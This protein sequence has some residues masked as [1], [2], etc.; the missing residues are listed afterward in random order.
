MR[1]VPNTELK[2]MMETY[3]NKDR[4]SVLGALENKK[5]EAEKAPKSS[6]PAKS[7]DAGMEK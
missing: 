4:S 3:K 1:D 7:K 2:T 6:K 5:K